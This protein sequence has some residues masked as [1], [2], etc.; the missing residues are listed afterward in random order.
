MNIEQTIWPALVASAATVVGA[1]ALSW[2]ILRTFKED[3]P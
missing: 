2:Y 1:M 3:W